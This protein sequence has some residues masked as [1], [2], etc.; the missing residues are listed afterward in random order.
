MNLLSCHF[1][2]IKKIIIRVQSHHSN[3][4]YITPPNIVRSINRGSKREIGSG[5]LH[6]NMVYKI[7]I[8]RKTK[9]G[10]IHS[11]IVLQIGYPLSSKSFNIEE[12]LMEKFI[13]G[14]VRWDIRSGHKRASDYFTYSLSS[15]KTDLNLNFR[16]VFGL[17]PSIN[18]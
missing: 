3:K 12:I 5:T 4:I 13:I 6:H 18:Q 1:N 11:N 15:L 7:N 16:E 9:I 17:T 8:F 10:I 14:I 2:C